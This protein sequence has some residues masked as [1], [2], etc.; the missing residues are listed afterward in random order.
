MEKTVSLESQRAQIEDVDLGEI[1]LKLKTQELAYQSALAITARTLQ[2]T[3]M[4]FL[5]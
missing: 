3:L 5:R 4:D 1:A 2:P